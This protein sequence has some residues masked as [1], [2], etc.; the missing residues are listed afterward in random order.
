MLEFWCSDVSGRAELEGV[1]WCRNRLRAI[2][3]LNLLGGGFANSLCDEG[4]AGADDCWEWEMVMSGV[5]Q[6]DKTGLLTGRGDSAPPA[7]TSAGGVEEAWS[8]SQASFTVGASPDGSNGSVCTSSTL[9]INALLPQKGVVSFQG[10]FRVCERV[11]T[12]S[13][14]RK[15]GRRPQRVHRRRQ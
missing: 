15:T 9:A 12:L 10:E 13:P 8:V 5:E 6:V 7:R 14:H 2:T 1:T 11:S 3:T 4:L